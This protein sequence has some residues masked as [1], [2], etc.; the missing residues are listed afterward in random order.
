MIP[1]YFSSLYLCLQLLLVASE[2]NTSI[3]KHATYY[4]SKRKNK[5]NSINH[6]FTNYNTDGKFRQLQC[7]NVVKKTVYPDPSYSTFPQGVLRVQVAK[8][9]T[10]HSLGPNMCLQTECMLWLVLLIFHRQIYSAIF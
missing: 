3:I 8:Q 4:R 9:T 6:C 7:D 1:L 10:Y 5:S 2:N